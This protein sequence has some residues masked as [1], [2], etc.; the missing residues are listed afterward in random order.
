VIHIFADELIEAAEFQRS[1][2]QDNDY[3]CEEW[4]TP[5]TEITKL[6]TPAPIETIGDVTDRAILVKPTIRVFGISRE[7]KEVNSEIATQKGSDPAMTRF[8]KYILARESFAVIRAIES[9]AR[10]EHYRRT[11]PWYDGGW[12]ALAMGAY[13]DYTAMWRKW[14][15][16]WEPAIQ[17]VLDNWDQIVAEG[18]KHLNGLAAKVKYPT[19]EEAAKKFEFSM[20][21]MP[22]PKVEDWRN[23][24]SAGEIAALKQQ[25]E[26]TL[27]QATE[28]A[29]RDIYARL[30]KVIGNMKDALS[31][32]D[33]KFKDTL[34]T[35]ITDIL[36]IVP[37][38]NLTGDPT[39]TAFCEQVQKELTKH[40]PDTLRN[41]KSVRDA[42]AR[43]AD[44]ILKKMAAFVA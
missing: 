44:E 21:A 30:A 9:N 38:L 18:K 24:L 17:D 1:I 7:D 3:E 5:K 31:D 20:A 10:Q 32:A 12:R 4:R 6:Q 34:V 22:I 33:K 37:A 13:H 15:A 23:D 43:K 41:N 14:K 29:N 25:Y 16:Q 36:A 8:I 40:D 26:D 35:N 27:K 28:Q 42:T 39:I 19:R 11:V 2:D